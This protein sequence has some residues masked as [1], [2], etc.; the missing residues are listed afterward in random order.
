MAGYDGSPA[1]ER[2]LAYATGLARRADR[3][4]VVV[5][6]WRLGGLVSAPL[7]RDAHTERVRQLRAELAG[8]DLL[9]LDVE[10]VSRVGDPAAEL[11]KVAEQRQADVL[12]IGASRRKKRIRSASV[13][14][15]VVRRASCPAVVVP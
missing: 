7:T 13:P 1:S 8:T 2:A 4:L 5:R 12:V 9:G 10:T 6:I 14:T 3:W 11:I 15:Q